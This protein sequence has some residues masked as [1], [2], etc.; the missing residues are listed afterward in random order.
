MRRRRPD[1]PTPQQTVP[2]R[3]RAFDAADWPAETAAESYELWSAARTAWAD[4]HGWPGGALDL[5]LSAVDA[6]C[7]IYGRRPSRRRS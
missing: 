5:F 4:E 2:A 6:K 7:A 3:L 1:T